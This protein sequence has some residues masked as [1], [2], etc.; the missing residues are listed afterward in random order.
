MGRLLDRISEIRR[1]RPPRRMA[2]DSLL[3]DNTPAY[4]R[5]QADRTIGQIETGLRELLDHHG[6]QRTGDAYPNQ[7]WSPSELS[8]FKGRA[9]AEGRNHDDAR[10]LLDYVLLP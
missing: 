1:R 4:R 7:L 3:Q 5:S 10:T 8:N 9:D 2:S 6:L